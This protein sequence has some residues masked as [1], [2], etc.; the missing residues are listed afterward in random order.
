MYC[1]GLLLGAPASRGT[2]VDQNTYDAISKATANGLA[3]QALLVGVVKALQKRGCL[4]VDVLN[5]AFEFADMV[6]IAG[7]DR[8]DVAGLAKQS[9]DTLEVLEGLREAIL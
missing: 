3:I 9:T 2:L 5:E 4:D 6:A 7:S 8:N 1:G